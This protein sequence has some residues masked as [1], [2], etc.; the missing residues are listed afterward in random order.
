[1]PDESINPARIK[2]ALL[3]LEEAQKELK[4]AQKEL[5]EALAEVKTPRPDA[6]LKSPTKVSRRRSMRRGVQ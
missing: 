1:M 5:E 4:A 3:K 2:N 6:P